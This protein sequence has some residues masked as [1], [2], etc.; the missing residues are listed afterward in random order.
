MNDQ[1]FP[2]PLHRFSE[3]SVTQ[4]QLVAQLVNTIASNRHIGEYNVAFL[5]TSLR[6]WIREDGR[7]LMVVED[8]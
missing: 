8:E 1:N 6:D 7:R 2:K 5:L 4:Q 3:L